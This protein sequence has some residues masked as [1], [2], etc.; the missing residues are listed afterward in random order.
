M[1]ADAAASRA[2]TIFLDESNSCGCAETTFVVLKEA[3]GLPDALNSS[4]AM[5][6]NGGVAYSGGVCGAI[7]GAALAVGLLAARRFESH[8]QAK[9]AA[10]EVIAG[11]MDDFRAEYGSVDCRALLGHDIRTP[12]Q[13]RAFIES[14]TWRVACMS[15]IEFAIRNLVDLPVREVW[16]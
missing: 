2:R 1:T 13:H 12:E 11:L 4:A 6:L 9:Q 14:G 16:E 5:S 8:A 7:T 15:Q 10:R 3:F